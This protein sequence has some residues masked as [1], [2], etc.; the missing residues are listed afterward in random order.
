MKVR[1]GLL[2][3]GRMIGVAVEMDGDRRA[4]KFINPYWEE[5]DKKWRETH[6]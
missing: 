4:F 5:I 6:G 1:A 2:D 3:C